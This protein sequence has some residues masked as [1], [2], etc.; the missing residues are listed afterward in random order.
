MFA[1]GYIQQ[2]MATEQCDVY[3]NLQTMRHTIRYAA[4]TRWPSHS[5]GDERYAK[6]T[7]Q[8]NYDIIRAFL[9]SSLNLEFQVRFRMHRL[10]RKWCGV[11]Q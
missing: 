8:D 10:L 5:R 7:I 3:H 11:P 6:M 1:T 2:L 9:L 4:T